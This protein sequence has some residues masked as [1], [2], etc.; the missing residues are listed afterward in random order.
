MRI[1]TILGK[2][3]AL[4]AARNTF[5]ATY[6]RLLFRASVEIFAYYM[7]VPTNI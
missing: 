5:A 4:T 7:E 3:V 6:A 1:K 2:L